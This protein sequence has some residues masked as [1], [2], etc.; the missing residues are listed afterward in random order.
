MEN[1]SG[2]KQ[3]EK[4]KINTAHKTLRIKD[5]PLADKVQSSFFFL[6]DLWPR[7]SSASTQNNERVSFVSMCE[8][9]CEKSLSPGSVMDLCIP[10]FAQWLLEICSSAVTWKGKSMNCKVNG[11]MD[12]MDLVC[13]KCFSWF[14]SISLFAFCTP[15]LALLIT[16]PALYLVIFSL[17]IYSAWFCL[18]SA[19]LLS[20]PVSLFWL[21]FLGF[22]SLFL[23]FCFFPLLLHCCALL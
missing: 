19:R 16:T 6:V 20:Q 3:V 10:T 12:C 8:W 14:M 5:N 1:Y 4:K 2:V 18:F 13:P 23:L 15:G 11:W 22:F 7:G 21:V 9:K 17:S